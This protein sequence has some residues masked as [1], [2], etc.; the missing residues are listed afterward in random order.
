MLFP[1]PKHCPSSLITQY[2]FQTLVTTDLFPTTT[3]PDHLLLAPPPTI[4]PYHYVTDNQL[5]APPPTIVPYHY[6]TRPSV[7]DPSPIYRSPPCHQTI[8]CR[9]LPQLSIPTTTSADNRLSA[10]PPT[11]I[12]YHYVTRPSVVGPSPN[13]RSLPLCH[14]TISCRPLPN[15]CSL[16][17]LHQTT[18]CVF[19]ALL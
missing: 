6:V 17:L 18:S 19:R 13:Y 15:S 9:P 16:P 14:Q 3:S 2:S 5:S 8:S 10:P 12:P 11:I 1:F 7:V 4:V